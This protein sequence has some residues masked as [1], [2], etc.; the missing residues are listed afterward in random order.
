[1]HNARN[2][3]QVL[4]APVSTLLCLIHFM[5]KIESFSWVSHSG[6]IK[7]I[8]LES[9]KNLPSPWILLNHFPNLFAL[10]SFPLLVLTPW[11][12]P[13]VI[14]LGAVPELGVGKS[15]MTWEI[16]LLDPRSPFW[17]LIPQK[18]CPRGKWYDKV[19]WCGR[20]RYAFKSFL[21][22]LGQ[23]PYNSKGYSFRGES[24]ATGFMKVITL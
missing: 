11:I 20:G 23:K 22:S 7:L 24:K 14:V 4:P 12:I 15:F 19:W 13:I 5:Y 1:M 17:L 3:N 6:I 10:K 21:S 16:S 9:E 2:R 8:K 18:N